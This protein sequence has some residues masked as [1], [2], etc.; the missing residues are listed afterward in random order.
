MSPF[1]LVSLLLGVVLACEAPS[2]PSPIDPA[3]LLREYGW[4][5]TGNRDFYLA[6]TFDTAATI[7]TGQWLLAYQVTRATD[8]GRFTGSISGNRITLDLNPGLNCTA[9]F[10]LVA[11]VSPDASRVHGR[12]TPQVGTPPAGPADT[13]TLIPRDVFQFPEQIRPCN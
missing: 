2:S 10:H 7:L 1:L 11:T 5:E 13:I 8:W 6:L 3:L 9:G 12:I 4:P